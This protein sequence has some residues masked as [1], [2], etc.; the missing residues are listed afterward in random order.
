MQTGLAPIQ[1]NWKWTYLDAT[2]R[3][4]GPILKLKEFERFTIG[5]TFNYLGNLVILCAQ[6]SHLF[7]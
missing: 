4:F 1:D 5:M 6:N 3:L 2:R 7:F